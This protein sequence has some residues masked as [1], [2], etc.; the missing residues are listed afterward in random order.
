[1]EAC[2]EAE[3]APTPVHE[4]RH[5][6][7]ALGLRTLNAGGSR[8]HHVAAYA[9]IMRG[10]SLLHNAKTLV[11]FLW[12]SNLQTYQKMVKSYAG[13]CLV[14]REGHKVKL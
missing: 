10:E 13:S 2:L 12:G 9:G 1:M 4:Q 8:A 14:R 7:A 6:R 5:V 11:S 3:R